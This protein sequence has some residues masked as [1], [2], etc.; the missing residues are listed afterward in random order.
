MP[1][2]KPIPSASDDK[3]SARALRRFLDDVR[4]QLMDRDVDGIPIRELLTDEQL[5]YLHEARGTATA[6]QLHHAARVRHDDARTRHRQLTGLTRQAHRHYLGE[7][8]VLAFVD[9][10]LS[11]PIRGTTRR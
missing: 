7:S 6:E 1:E 9:R 11:D 8:E 3:N 10:L 5:A 4:D 2:P